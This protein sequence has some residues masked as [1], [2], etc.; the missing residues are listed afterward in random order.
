MP[1]YPARRTTEYGT[2][3]VSRSRP[4]QRALGTVA[5]RTDLRLAD[6]GSDTE[7]AVAV[8]QARNALAAAAAQADATLS[9]ILNA[10]PISD[11]MDA[12]FRQQLKQTTRA[13]VIADI[14]SFEP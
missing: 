8:V 1:N 13:R 11:P 6:I 14:W 5:G 12:D 10:L 2:L 4:L 9:G 7:E 3:E